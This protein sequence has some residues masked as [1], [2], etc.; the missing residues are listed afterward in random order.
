M[1]VEIFRIFS[2]FVFDKK[3]ILYCSVKNVK[4]KNRLDA[5][6]D[7]IVKRMENHIIMFNIN[8]TIP[9]RFIN[10]NNTVS[11]LHILS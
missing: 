2:V 11:P 5:S 8:R 10:I 1:N 6:G 4:R 3:S 7:C 9:E